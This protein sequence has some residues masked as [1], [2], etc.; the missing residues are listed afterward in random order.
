M[1]GII[2][3]ALVPLAAALHDVVVVLSHFLKC[4]VDSFSVAGPVAFIF[5]AEELNVVHFIVADHC[6]VGCLCDFAQVVDEDESGVLR[7]IVGTCNTIAGDTA[8]V[9]KFLL[10]AVGLT[11]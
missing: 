10:D 3:D 11:K 1:E 2:V 7:D 6:K 4:R 9:D 5:G 8:L